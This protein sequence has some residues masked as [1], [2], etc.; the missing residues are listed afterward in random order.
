MPGDHKAM[1]CQGETAQNH[2]RWA[3]HP[4]GSKSG[5][6]LQP[7]RS[8][9]LQNGLSL[10]WL[11]SWI[12]KLC[13]SRKTDQWYCMPKRTKARTSMPITAPRIHTGN[14]AISNLLASKP[15]SH[16]SSPKLSPADPILLGYQRQQYGGRGRDRR[17]H[18]CCCATFK[19]RSLV[20]APVFVRVGSN[21]YPAFPLVCF[22]ILCGYSREITK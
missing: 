22:I 17:S 7:T 1:Y 5:A 8:R 18:P 14:R 11:T 4:V 10:C 13:V 12:C 9:Q 2:A 6:G 16:P 21:L 15:C 3:G 19:V 20:A